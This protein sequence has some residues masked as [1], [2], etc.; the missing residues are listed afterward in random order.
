VEVAGF[1]LAG[2]K[3]SRMGRD[4][5]LLELD[6]KTLV[7]IGLRKLR[8]VCT[9]V[10]IAGGTAELARFGRVIPDGM[11]GC[12]PLGGLVAALEDSSAEWNLFLPVDVP[13][14]P[15]EALR[16]LLSAAGGMNVAVMAEAGG[17]VHPLCGV[18]SRGAL[19]ALQ[20]ALAAGRYRVRAAIE[21]AG[22]VSRVRFEEDGWFR[23]VNTP[24]EF[25]ELEVRLGDI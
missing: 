22:Q 25:A 6:G 2:G 11:A 13:L 7:Q 21:A 24:E 23:N 15:V 5:A 1:L 3:S 4:K 14:V 16:R 9:E 12:G 8:E 18:Y 19:P 20:A 17:R 10:A